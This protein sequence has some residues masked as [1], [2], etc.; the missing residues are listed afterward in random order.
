MWHVSSAGKRNT[1]AACL[2]GRCDCGRLVDRSAAPPPKDDPHDPPGAQRLGGRPKIAGWVRK[3]QA[4]AVLQVCTFLFGSRGS[5][6]FHFF[7][8][9]HGRFSAPQDS[10]SQILVTYRYEG[11]CIILSLKHR[12]LWRL[13][14]DCGVALPLWAGHE[15][16]MET[17]G[18]HGQT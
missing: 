9:K 3:D 18:A 11:M 6:S 7:D 10:R 2:N 12:A 15:R 13:S 16:D 1:L 4:T 5:F 17:M 8:L 14:D